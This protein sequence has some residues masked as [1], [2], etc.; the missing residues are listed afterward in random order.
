[1]FAHLLAI[2]VATLVLVWLLHFRRGL[3]FE[4]AN[5]DKILNVHTLLMVVGFILVAGEA[6]M[7]YKSVPAKRKV[8]KVFHVTL[9][10]M[11]LLAG[12]VGVYT[13]FRFKHERLIFHDLAAVVVGA[14]LICVPRCRNVSKRL[15]QA[16]ARFWGFGNIFPRYMHSPDGFAGNFKFLRPRR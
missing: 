1:M 6:T 15:I 10:L 8:Q 11:A 4:S 16:M 2:A 13:A 9:H 5:K 7:A 12:V 14:L 3:A